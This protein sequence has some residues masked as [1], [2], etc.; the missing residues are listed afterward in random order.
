[1]TSSIG[2]RFQR[3]LRFKTSVD[4]VGVHSGRSVRLTLLPGAANSGL[5]FVRTD[6]PHE[7]EIPAR[8]EFVVD[9]TL[10][11]TLG[12]GDV[13]IGTVEH[14]LAALYALGVDN[15]RIEVD[16][17]EIPILDG[18]AAPFVRLI[19]EAGLREQRAPRVVAVVKKVATVVDGDKEVRLTPGSGFSIHCGVDFRHP[20]IT[21]QKYGLDVNARSFV[22]EI[23]RART[24]GFVREVEMLRTRGLALG[25]SLENAIVVDDF[26][27]LNPEGLRFP[28]EFVRHKILDAVGDLALVGMPIIGHLH[29]HKTGHALNQR[30]V[31]K[32][33]TEPGYLDIVTLDVPEPRGAMEVRDLAM[34]SFE[35]SLA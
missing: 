27:I 26:H 3:T 34:A 33:L 25:G 13:R 11:T 18:S 20:L 28:D 21:N 5:V 1:M 29:A 2:P 31:K 24:F 4:G 10:N 12:R 30:L 22:R 6:L 17:P 15:A 32:L 8:S 19:D 35:G 7:I 23:A 14:L 16:G 9:T